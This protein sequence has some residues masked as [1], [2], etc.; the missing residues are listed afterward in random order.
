MVCPTLSNSSF[1]V[2]V[3]SAVA[4]TGTTNDIDES[5]AMAVLGMTIKV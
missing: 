2:A 3:V 4:F 5:T 1:M